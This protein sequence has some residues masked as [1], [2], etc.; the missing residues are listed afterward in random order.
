LANI[1][2]EFLIPQAI[3]KSKNEKEEIYFESETNE[4]FNSHAEVTGLS[5]EEKEHKFS[6]AEKEMLKIKG[7]REKKKTKTNKL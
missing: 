5:D 2:D 6:F 7:K 3:L 4:I 1:L